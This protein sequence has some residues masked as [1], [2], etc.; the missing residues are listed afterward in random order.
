MPTEAWICA[1]PDDLLVQILCLIPTKDA[2]T[3]MILSKRWR[4][5]W[6]MLPKLDYKENFED[7]TSVWDFLDKS[8]QL[9]KAP[10]L[11]RLRIHLGKQCPVDVDVGKWVLNAVERFV[12][13]LI[14]EIR[15][16]PT[17]DP[18]SLPK[19]LYTCKA[20][21]KLTLTHKILVD[22]PSLPCLPS[23]KSLALVSVVYKDQGSHV[24]LLSSCPV[25]RYLCVVRNK[26]DNVTKFIV[27]LP[28]LRSLGYM[29][30]GYGRSLVIDSPGLKYL[31]IIDH[32]LGNNISI[33][34]MPCLLSAVVFRTHVKDKFLTSLS[35]VT[36]LNLANIKVACCSTINFS[37]LRKF[38]LYPSSSEHCWM[39][40]LVLLLHSA[41][42]LKALII[43]TA[44]DGRHGEVPLS[45]NQPS[46]VPGCLLSRL[47][48]FEW[49]DFGGSREEKQFVA[50]ILENSKCLKTVGISLKYSKN[51]EEK[52]KIME[53]LESMYRVSASSQLL[54]RS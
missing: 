52:K 43:N 12:R 10:S 26:S 8:L 47:D 17:A 29:D 24:R 16:I 30:D 44:F 46:S 34:N 23:L 19:S 36:C 20:L 41:P 53:D 28:S 11:E 5:V 54:L 14:L 22:V 42:K 21:V 50:Y 45:W 39:E 37:R 1:L 48:N 51:N 33:Q 40:T 35:S 7:E 3:T 13:E 38:Q 9:H 4:F 31:R 32:P 25:L 27:K 2:V 18:T 6:T 15:F 49:I